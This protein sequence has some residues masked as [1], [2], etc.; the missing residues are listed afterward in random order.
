MKLLILNASP[1]KRGVASQFFSGILRLFLPGLVKKTVPLRSRKDFDHALSQLGSADAVCISFPLYVDGLPSH[2]AEFLS[3]AEEYCKARSLRFR[4]Y[5][6]ANNGFIEGQQN[7]TALR[8]LESW[9]LH[10]GAVWSGGI[11]IGGGVMLRVLGIVYPVLIALSIVQIAVS[12]LMA[13]S[14]PP[15]MLYTLAIQ[16]GSW[17]FFNFG[18]LFCLARLSAAVYKRKTVKSRY[19]RVLLPSFLFVPIADLFM[20][21][22]SLSCGRFLFALLKQD[23][24][25]RNKG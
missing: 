10:S 23:D 16:A 15:D 19:T 1:K 25:S 22:S 7:C 6:I 3:L 18:V 9:C 11:G 4:L 17:L 20:I 14:V 5:A 21:L 12:F 2:L 24:C 8:I 13:G